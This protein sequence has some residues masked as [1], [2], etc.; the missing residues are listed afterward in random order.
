[1]ENR[2][3]CFSIAG[4]F[5]PVC[6]SMHSTSTTPSDNAKRQQYVDCDVFHQQPAIGARL[7]LHSWVKR[8]VVLHSNSMIRNFGLK[9]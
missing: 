9:T 4:G 6:E 2:I 3:L 7:L 8:R 1:M 5:F